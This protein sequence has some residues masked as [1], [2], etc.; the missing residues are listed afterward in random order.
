MMIHHNP[1]QTRVFDPKGNETL[2]FARQ[3]EHLKLALTYHT[4]VV[5]VDMKL[6]RPQ[7]GLT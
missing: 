7:V 6:T 3:A 4:I 5:E 2:L 1:I